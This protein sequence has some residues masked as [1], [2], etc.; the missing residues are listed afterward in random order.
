[1]DAPMELLTS[2]R[3]R[4]RNRQWPDEVKARIVAETLRPGATVGEVAERHG[5]KANHVSSWRTLARNGKLVLPAPEDPVEFA[6]LMVAPVDEVAAA[7]PAVSISPEVVVGSVIIRLEP[8]ASAVRIA[9]V[10]HALMAA[11]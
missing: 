7:E 8:G 5:L 11:S 3:R 4:R 1:M 10:V 2:G 6:T 9:S